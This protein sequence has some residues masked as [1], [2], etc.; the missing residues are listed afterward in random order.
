[1]G[2][3]QR[4]CM[5]QKCQINRM[6]GYDSVN[7][8]VSSRMRKVA[9]DGADVSSGSRLFHTRGPATENAPLPTCYDEFLA[10]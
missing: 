8:N 2:A 10:F 9:R 4:Q 1:M 5:T 7:R 3:L 6:S